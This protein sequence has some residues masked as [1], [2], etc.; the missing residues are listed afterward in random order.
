MFSSLWGGELL[1]KTAAFMMAGCFS[2]TA[3]VNQLVMV[4]RL[5][6]SGRQ[7]PI[8]SVKTDPAPAPAPAQWKQ[9]LHF[10]TLK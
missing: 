6:Q 9:H 3:I 4:V 8:K 7:M 2:A 10:N 5:H 1:N